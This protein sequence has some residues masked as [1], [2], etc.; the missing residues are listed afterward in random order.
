MK[1]STW[2]VVFLSV[3]VICLGGTL[4]AIYGSKLAWYFGF[5]QDGQSHIESVPIENWTGLDRSMVG[6][7]LEVNVPYGDFQFTLPDGFRQSVDGLVVQDRTSL[8]CDS[9]T[10]H[11]IRLPVDN[12]LA[13]SE[14]FSTTPEFRRDDPHWYVKLIE[15]AYAV[16]RSSF[17]WSMSRDEFAYFRWLLQVAETVRS[18]NVNRVAVH[19]GKEIDMVVYFVDK[20]AFIEVYPGNGDLFGSLVIDGGKCGTR[21]AEE[22]AKLIGASISL[23]DAE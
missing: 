4:L 15:D 23:R 10:V 14:R 7:P 8:T 12:S 3:L 18:A 9:M 6:W 2:L 11:F 20:G 22:I 13:K 17:K 21:S 5:A 1:R 16:S 19:Y